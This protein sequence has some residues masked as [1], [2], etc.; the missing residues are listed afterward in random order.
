MNGQPGLLLLLLLP[1][2]PLP[3]LPPLPLLPLL[4]PTLLLLLRLPPLPLL[5]S[6]A[7]ARSILFSAPR[8]TPSL[9]IP[10][11]ALESSACCCVHAKAY[12]RKYRE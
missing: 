6:A 10:L 2:L 3:P 11:L 5:L 7:A 8:R 9:P 12:G 4:P 1:L